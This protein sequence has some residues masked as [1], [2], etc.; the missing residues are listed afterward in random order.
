MIVSAPSIGMSS[1]GGEIIK[2]CNI[3][4]NAWRSPPLQMG[5]LVALFEEKR[6]TGGV[7]VRV[8]RLGVGTV[9]LVKCSNGLAT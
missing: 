3:T 7:G 6:T 2:D 4:G 8:G 1:H 9:T 5:F